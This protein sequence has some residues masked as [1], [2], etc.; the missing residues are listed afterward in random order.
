MG[1]VDR[2]RI[3]EPDQTNMLAR[4]GFG[5]LGVND[6]SSPDIRPRDCYKE[7]AKLE[8]RSSSLGIL[9]RLNVRDFG[10]VHSVGANILRTDKNCTVS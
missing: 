10:Q 7:V 8:L 9:R 2:A 1:K 5:Y 3:D 6:S 4:I